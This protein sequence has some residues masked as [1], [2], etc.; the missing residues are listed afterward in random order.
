MRAPRSSSSRPLAAL[1]LLSGLLSA[2]AACKP[3]RPA[4]FASG[5]EERWT[6]PLVGTVE[7]APLLTPVLVDGQGPF[8]FALDPDASVSVIDETLVAQL[9]LT[10]AKGPD[11]RDVTGA[12]RTRFHAEVRAIEIG[13]L[14]V[15]RLDAMIASTG[16]FDT[17]GRRVHGV[18]GRDVLGDGLVLGIDRD[19]GVG[20]LVTR[21]AWTPPAGAVP[22]AYTLVPAVPA[23]GVVAPVPRRVVAAEV[24]G[25]EVALHVDLGAALSQLREARWAP[26]ALPVAEATVHLV[27]ET[28][29]T[30]DASRVAR[31]AV[32][33]G[34]LTA[35]VVFVP[36][37]DVRFPEAA[38]DG[39]LGLDAFAGVDV[40]L[41]P[42]ERGLY[43]L[44]RQPVPL[45]TRAA[46]WDVGALGACRQ[47]GCVSIR[48]VDPVAGRP[49]DPSKPHPGLVLSV[50]REE[51]AGGMGLEVVVEA[52]GRPELPRLAINLP[53]TADRVLG[54]LPPA[55]LGAGLTVVDVSPYPRACPAADGCVDTL[56]R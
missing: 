46:R 22:L 19:A 41:H 50:T 26:A 54:H 21:A 56:A 8:L 5:D 36:Y 25:Q 34:P 4:G 49:A 40:W 42:G 53:P 47:P 16:T 44:P 35:Q 29:T 12:V 32:T 48:L 33:A 28:G 11:R 43:L 18:L 23:A 17:D 51:T 15:E 1:G 20:H 27:D 37:A 9:G 13:T 38:V 24:G 31:G 2:L 10:A 45:A 3:G 14:I 30:R 55:W 7:T 52:T 6:F 39:A